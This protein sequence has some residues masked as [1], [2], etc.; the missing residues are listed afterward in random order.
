MFPRRSRNPSSTTK[1]STSSNHTGASSSSNP[2]QDPKLRPFLLPRP[3][4]DPT[5]GL[6]TRNSTGGMTDRSNKPQPF[7]PFAPRLADFRDLVVPKKEGERCV[8]CNSDVVLNPRYKPDGSVNVAEPQPGQTVFLNR[9]KN[10]DGTDR[11]QEMVWSCR[12]NRHPYPYPH[13]LNAHEI[14][15]PDAPEGEKD[16]QRP[17]GAR[18]SVPGTERWVNEIQGFLNRGE[19]QKANEAMMELVL[20]NEGKKPESFTWLEEH[21]E[22]SKSRIAKGGQ[23]KVGGASIA[24]KNEKN[25][26]RII[27]GKKAT[28][29]IDTD[30]KPRDPA[31]NLA[32]SLTDQIEYGGIT[33][34]DDLN[35][36]KDKDGKHH[37]AGFQQ[38]QGFAAHK[39]RKS[40]FRPNPN[41]YDAALSHDDKKENVEQK[42]APG[43]TKA[44]EYKHLVKDQ[45]TMADHGITK[46]EEDKGMLPV[47]PAGQ[48]ATSKQSASKVTQQT[49]S[50]TAPANVSPPVTTKHTSARARRSQRTS[51]SAFLGSLLAGFTQKSQPKGL[52]IT[53]AE[54]TDGPVTTAAPQ[55]PPPSPRSMTLQEMVT[56]GFTKIAGEVQA[57]DVEGVDMS[58][59]YVTA[60]RGDEE[61]GEVG[62]VVDISMTDKT[63][64]FMTDKSGVEGAGGNI[65]TLGPQSEG[66]GSDKASKE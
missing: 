12:I 13:K 39:G 42:L 11:I 14:K 19:H 65:G 66:N 57:G 38:Y 30:T 22:S 27:T 5:A 56:G 31:S 21:G 20:M 36:Q 47:V 33:L 24:G 32:K 60:G 62:G 48:R 28:E 41:F 63:P 7:L 8:K 58:T 37:V 1:P 52:T 46:Y 50:G 59:L 35:A 4:S 29:E 44:H 16:P 3:S 43:S 34:S 10:P 25:D 64:S 61:E 53:A 51:P 49:A 40:A 23:N 18:M 15:G 45:N 54:Q 26:N 55:L 17:A 9:G 6:N 2:N